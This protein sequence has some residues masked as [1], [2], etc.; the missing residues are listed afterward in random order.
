MTEQGECKFV[1][2]SMSEEG[3]KLRPE[4]MVTTSVSEI[5]TQTA[6]KI[7]VGIEIVTPGEVRLG[8]DINGVRVPAFQNELE[9]ATYLNGNA[10]EIKSYAFDLPM[11]FIGDDTLHYPV[12]FKLGL[13]WGKPDLREIG[14]QGRAEYMLRITGKGPVVKYNPKQDSD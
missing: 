5:S 4:Q 7:F 3:A 9:G 2:I 12:D 6:G 14:F 13:W 1:G 8:L 10:G 11:R